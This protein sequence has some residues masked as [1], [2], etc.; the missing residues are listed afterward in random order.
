M[1]PCIEKYLWDFQLRLMQVIKPSSGETNIIVQASGPKPPAT[2]FES[3]QLSPSF[4]ETRSIW[5]LELNPSKLPVVTLV[6]FYNSWG[7]ANI[8][9]RHWIAKMEH[10]KELY[11]YGSKQ[12]LIDNAL[13]DGYNY[14]V[15]KHKRNGEIIVVE[16]NC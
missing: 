13:Q 1:I 2:A 6:I 10:S 3:I 16:S 7:N 11:D 15:L 14:K 8:K 4:P 5:E 9:N 12:F